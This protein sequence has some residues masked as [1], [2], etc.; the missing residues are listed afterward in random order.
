[1][2]VADQLAGHLDDLILVCGN[3][4][5]STSRSKLQVYNLIGIKKRTPIGVSFI[6]TKALLYY[7]TTIRVT[8][9]NLLLFTSTR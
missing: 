2:E 1:M 7:F 4:G 3:K 6:T 5:D 8:F 9:L